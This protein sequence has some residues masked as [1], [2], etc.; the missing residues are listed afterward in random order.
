MAKAPQL[1]VVQ[2]RIE[3]LLGRQN[4]PVNMSILHTLYRSKYKETLD[5]TVLGFPKLK[6]LME[7]IPSVGFSMHKSELRIFLIP[8]AEYDLSSNGSGSAS[9]TTS[10]LSSSSSS[11]SSSSK[12]SFSTHSS[13]DSPCEKF[14]IGPR[15][16]PLPPPPLP[17]KRQTPS[18]TTTT[19]TTTLTSDFQHLNLNVEKK[20][21]HEILDK[22]IS[23]GKDNILEEDKVDVSS[24]LA[25][26]A[27]K[28]GQS[29]LQLQ[30]QR[31]SL[32][33]QAAAACF[34]EMSLLGHVV[35]DDNDVGRD[36]SNSALPAEKPVFLNTHEPFCLTAVGVQGA[37]KSHSLATVLESCLVQCESDQVT[38]L[39]NPMTA[40]V[41]HYDQ[42]TTAVCEAAG[43]LL[44]SPK[45]RQR[46]SVPKSKAVVLVSPTF[47]SQ[48][49]KFYGDFCTVRPLLFK[50][51]SLTADHIKYVNTKKLLLCESCYN[52]IISFSCLDHLN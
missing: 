34:E 40:L 44:P 43:L 49:K 7:T 14:V 10:Q 5:Y 6:S 48:R 3:T 11:D 12:L 16:R 19:T 2:E 39:H 24:L 20:S 17:K 51:N 23:S 15:N 8:D 50:W 18:T 35:D 1:C 42:N 27:A 41:L 38:R 29:A 28:A 37:G 30:A 47:F 26:P 52:S 32:G 13:D 33:D 22:P 46:A 4:A 9:P 45:I 36:N 31:A 21:V 25:Q